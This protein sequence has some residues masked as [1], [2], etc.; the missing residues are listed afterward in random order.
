MDELIALA[1]QGAW[2]SVLLPSG[3]LLPQFPSVR[4]DPDAIAHIRQGRTFRM[5]PFVESSGA[6]HVRAMSGEGELVAIGE[7]RMPLVYH[8]IVVL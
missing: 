7:A 8:P 4:V 3:T 5:S 1:A 6:L 2:A